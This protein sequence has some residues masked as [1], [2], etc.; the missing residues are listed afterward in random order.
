MAYSAGNSDDGY[1]RLAQLLAQSHEYAIFR[2]FEWL[3]MMNLLRLQAE[4]Q[5]MEQQLVEVRAEDKDPDDDS[6][7][8]RSYGINF[9]AM[10]DNAEDGDSEQYDLLLEISP[11]LDE[12]NKALQNIAFLHKTVQPSEAE[13]EFLKLWLQRDKMGEGFFRRSGIEA[14]VWD[15]QNAEDLLSVGGSPSDRFTNFMHGPV[16]DFYHFVI[17]RFTKGRL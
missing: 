15:D 8:R 7:V 14:K 4:L 12:Y 1:G 17:G 16:I 2:K 6:E 11:K 3:N 5:H 9:K 13:V 10:R